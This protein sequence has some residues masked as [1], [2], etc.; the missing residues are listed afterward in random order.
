MSRPLS[1]YRRYIDARCLPTPDAKHAA[2]AV[3]AMQS[4]MLDALRGTAPLPEE[5]RLH[6]ALAFEYLCA[7]VEFDLVTPVKKPGGREAPIAKIAQ[8]DGIRY[9]RWCEA[10]RIADAAPVNTVAAAYSVEPRTVRGWRAAWLDRATPPLA[11]GL[12]FEQVIDF[13]RISGRAYRRFVDK[14]KA[15]LK[16]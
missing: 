12:G 1:P 10:G 14:P 2:D 13:M 8:E 6:L 16:A 5:M 11:K 15:R 3:Q 4:A 7:G 9:L